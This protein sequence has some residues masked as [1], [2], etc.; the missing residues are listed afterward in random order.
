MKLCKKRYAPRWDCGSV[1]ELHVEL[2]NRKKKTVQFFQ[3]KRV[4]F[5]QWNDQQLEQKTYTFKDYGPGVRF[6]RFKHRGKDT[7]FW[8]GHYGIRVTHS[9][10]EICPSA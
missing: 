7:Q 6:I 8:A 5:P 3:P 10:V 1:Y 2:L 9:S 4:K